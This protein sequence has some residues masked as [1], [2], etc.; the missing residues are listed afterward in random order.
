MPRLCF[1]VHD[2][3]QG[4][5]ALAAATEA[6]ASPVLASAPGAAGY[7]GAGTWRALEELWR[8]AFPETPFL[9][10]L[11]CGDSAGDAL[12]A[13]RAGVRAL[14]LEGPDEIV[15]RIADLAG[16]QGAAVNPATGPA[17]DL[18]AARDPLAAARNH[19]ARAGA[20]AVEKGAGP[21]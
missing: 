20:H 12:A 6:G 18:G 19:F 4:R 8:E 16:A 3:A 21:G 15:A 14:C 5:A 9:G 13:L 7:L 2:L 10:L 17:C 11:D 1:V